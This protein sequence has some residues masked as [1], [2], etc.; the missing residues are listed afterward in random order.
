MDAID[1]NF[2]IVQNA[3]VIQKV[4]K[5]IDGQNTDNKVQSVMDSHVNDNKPCLVPSRCLE[6]T[7][8]FTTQMMMSIMRWKVL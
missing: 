8:Q 1:F 2:H 3:M 5:S 7:T 4:T 6:C